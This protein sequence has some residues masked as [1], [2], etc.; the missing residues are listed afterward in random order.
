MDCGLLNK[1]WLL[2]KKFL[3]G[4]LAKKERLLQSQLLNAIDCFL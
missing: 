2:N 4:G 3:K 1:K